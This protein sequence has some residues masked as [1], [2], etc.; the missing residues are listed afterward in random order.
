[1]ESS[2][3][4]GREKRSTREMVTQRERFDVRRL[5]LAGFLYPG[6]RWYTLY[7]A[8]V[9]IEWTA[10]HLGGSRPWFQ[11]PDCRRRVAILYRSELGLRCRR[12]L[13]LAY[14]SQRQ[15]ARGR[16]AQRASKIRE[17][18][19]GAPGLLE[20]FPSKPAR[21]HWR[22][23]ERLKQRAQEAAQAAL[24]GPNGSTRVLQEGLG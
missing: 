5:Y 1:M 2:R 4:R 10:C 3:S 16:A 15:D 19:G 14:E 9:V 6:I 24:E 13:N 20:P 17:L 7:P 23:Y 8:L 22:T 11:C 18:L 12:C 21:M